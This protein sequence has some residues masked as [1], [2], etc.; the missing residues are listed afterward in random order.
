MYHRGGNN[1]SG[2]R[3]SSGISYGEVADRSNEKHEYHF[4]RSEQQNKNPPQARQAWPCGKGKRW[5]WSWWEGKGREGK[6]SH[7]AT[8]KSTQ[9]TTAALGAKFDK[10]NLLDDDSEVSSEEEEGVGASSRSTKA[11]TCHI[12][13]KGK[14]S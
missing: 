8:I 14:I 3:I 6:G 2:K 12:K 9:R 1:S 4:L 13:K 5:R 10:F 11:L 7:A